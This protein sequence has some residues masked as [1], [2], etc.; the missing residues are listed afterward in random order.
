MTDVR[1]ILPL[2]SP[3]SDATPAARPRP[4]PRPRVS[5]DRQGE[6]LSP[7]FRALGEAF[8]AGRV[9]AGVTPT[10]SDPELV[11]VFDLAGTVQEFR[12][13]VS[14]VAGLEFLAELADEEFEPDD[15]FHV[16]RDGVRSTTLLEHTLYTMM[17]SARAADELI[18]LFERWRAEPAA[19]FPIGTTPLRTAF[20]QLRAVR[21]WG[22]QD[23]EDYAKP[24]EWATGTRALKY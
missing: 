14:N 13:A 18:R 23:R 4:I 12:R 9:A 8:A 10:E 3:R 17:S 16:A 19:P 6:R 1:P 22:P 2:G 5:A 11:V 7:Q 20:E 24:P 15:D 21:R